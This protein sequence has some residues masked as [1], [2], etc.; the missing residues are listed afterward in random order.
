MPSEIDEAMAAPLNSHFREA[1]V[2]EYQEIIQYDIEYRH[3]GSADTK[4]FCKGNSGI[5]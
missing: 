1:Q 4:V 2:T 3:D 5:K